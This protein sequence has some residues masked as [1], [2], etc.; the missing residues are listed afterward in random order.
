MKIRSDIRTSANAVQKLRI[1][2]SRANKP[3][4]PALPLLHLRPS[5][6]IRGQPRSVFS[7]VQFLREFLCILATLCDRFF[8]SSLD[9]PLSHSSLAS[10]PSVQSCPPQFKGTFL[11]FLWGPGRPLPA[12][13]SVTI[14]ILSNDHGFSLPST[15]SLSGIAFVW[16]S[17]WDRANRVT[18]ACH[19]KRVAS[20]SR[21]PNWP[22]RRFYRSPLSVPLDT[23]V[24]AP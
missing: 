18:Q 11:A 10:L 14:W 16:G 6:S 1:N 12:A 2:I 15:S 3:T 17:I 8:A 20:K 19:L 13:R 23:S 7:P 24:G 4:L 9:L 5:A 22:Y 21:P